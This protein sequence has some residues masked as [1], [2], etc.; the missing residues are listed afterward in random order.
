MPTSTYP[1]AMAALLNQCTG[2][3]S[4]LDPKPDVITGA[5]GPEYV[6][7]RYVS[8][9]T[10]LT[11]DIS[12]DVK[13]LPLRQDNVDESYKI[14]LHL[15]C[16]APSRRDTA[17]NLE[18]MVEVFSWLDLIDGGLRANKPNYTLG[19]LVESAIVTNL[20]PSWH[21]YKEGRAAQLYVEVAVSA[22]R[23]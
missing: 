10:D 12:R 14:G 19:S 3:V 7:N 18:C 2:Y 17:A 6:P 22:T 11:G 23:I 4:S 5:P 8:V 15:W 9:G 13:R 1:L 16:F 21:F 20:T